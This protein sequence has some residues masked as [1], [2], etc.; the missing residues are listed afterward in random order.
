MSKRVFVHL[1]LL[2]ALGALAYAAGPVGGNCDGCEY[3]L[4]EQPKE[5]GSSARIAP[6]GEPGEALHIAGTVYRLDGKTPAPD[7]IVYAYHTNAEGVYPKLAAADGSAI[8]HGRL[9]GWARTDAKGNYA[10]DTIRP[11]AYPGHTIPQ[12]V[13]MHVIEPGIAEAYYLDDLLFSDDPFL[14]AEARAR[15]NGRGGNGIATPTRDAGGTWQVRRDIV[16][17]KNIPNYPA[18]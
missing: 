14:T 1:L 6:R 18:R 5:F 8:R 9:R 11:A 17:G 2:L 16:L 15:Q 12:H 4:A 7:V 3:A 10:F 13:H